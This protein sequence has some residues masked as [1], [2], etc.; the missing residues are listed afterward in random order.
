MSLM[1]TCHSATPCKLSGFLF[2]MAIFNPSA[3]IKPLYTLPK[4]P[5]PITLPAPKFLVAALN[6]AK[7]NTLRFGAFKISPRGNSPPSLTP[8]VWLFS[9]PQNDV[10]VLFPDVWLL[11]LLGPNRLLVPPKWLL[12]PR[13]VELSFCIS[14]LL[15]RTAE[16]WVLP[17]T[18]SQQ[19][20]LCHLK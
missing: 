2:L 16:N 18:S 12:H 8:E 1:L 9:E 6:S 5:S 11:L 4:P 10:L 3:L 14:L 19:Y 17:E 13:E 20:K 7:V 15:L